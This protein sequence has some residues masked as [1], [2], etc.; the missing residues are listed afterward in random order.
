MTP[1]LPDSSS[2]FSAWGWGQAWTLPMQYRRQKLLCDPS[3][4]VQK[5][6]AKA[7][8]ITEIFS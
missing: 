2:V 5:H 8:K 3:E 6:I 4:K 1:A 7:R